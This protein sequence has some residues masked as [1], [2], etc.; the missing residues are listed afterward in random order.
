MSPAVVLVASSLR[1]TLVLHNSIVIAESEAKVCAIGRRGYLYS[2]L[3][4]LCQHTSL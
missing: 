3:L 4:Q 2:R 1:R